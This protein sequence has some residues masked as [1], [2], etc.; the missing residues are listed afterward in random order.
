MLFNQHLISSLRS[1]A[2]R[3]PPKRG[4]S[5]LKT[6]DSDRYTAKSPADNSM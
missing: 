5:R 2:E 1:L 6:L 3:I 4:T